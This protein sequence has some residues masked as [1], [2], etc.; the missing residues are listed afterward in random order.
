MLPGRMNR[1]S[2]LLDRHL[3]VRE[4]LLRSSIVPVA[5]I[6]VDIQ[7]FERFQ[8]F[9]EIGLIREVMQ[10]TRSYRIGGF[11]GVRLDSFPVAVFAVPP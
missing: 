1:E 11:V 10:V 6:D 2:S 4:K 9:I 7:Y 8:Q 5:F 3:P